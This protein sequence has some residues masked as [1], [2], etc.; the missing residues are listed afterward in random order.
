ME[1][2]GKSLIGFR[3]STSAAGPFHAWNP[4]TGEKI[5][6]IF[7]SASQEDIERAAELA[8]EAFQATLV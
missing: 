5:D 1:I 3:D 6:L 2:L 7:Y 8:R 4:A